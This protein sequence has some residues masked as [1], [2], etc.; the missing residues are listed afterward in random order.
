MF[1]VH[2]SIHGHFGWFHILAIVNNA[3]VNIWE[4]I[5]F[6]ISV[7]IFFRYTPRSGIAV[8][9]GTSIFNFLRNLHNVSHRGCTN[10]HSHQQCTRVP[11]SPHP[12]QHLWF[13]VFLITDIAILTGVR[14]YFIVVLICNSL[15]I[16]DVL[17]CL[18]AIFMS[19]LE[20]FLFKFSAHFLSRLFVF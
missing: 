20:K 10:L 5:S 6:Q 14:W 17:M 3:A 4:H 2:S 19:S 9:Y 8:L 18:L 1:Y 15:M 13:V 7:F 16:C 12:H 11:F